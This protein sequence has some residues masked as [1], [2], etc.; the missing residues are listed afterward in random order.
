[1]ANDAFTAAVLK[2][3]LRAAWNDGV[4]TAKGYGDNV[5]HLEGA[6][7]DRHFTAFLQ[8][9]ESGVSNPDAVA[10]S[11]TSQ[12]EPSTRVKNSSSSESADV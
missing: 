10:R 11:V 9:L 7:A 4:K 3:W 6:Q 1:M 8:E 5:F 12:H 2:L